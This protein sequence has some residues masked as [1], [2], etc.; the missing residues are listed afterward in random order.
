LRRALLGLAL[1]AALGVALLLTRPSAPPPEPVR[2]PEPADAPP[3][4]PPTAPAPS[5]ATAPAAPADE[6]AERR[7]EIREELEASIAEHL[8]DLKL[9]SDQLDAASDALLRLRAAHLELAALPR[10]P[11]NAERLRELTQA[12]GQASL[13][14]EYVVGLDPAEFTERVSEEEE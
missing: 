11:E 4:A 13:D 8:P 7:T 5:R 2:P 10:T 12:I 1:A 3:T 6:E 14:F 9:S